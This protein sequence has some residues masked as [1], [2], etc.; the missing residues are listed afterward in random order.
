MVYICHFRVV[1]FLGRQNISAYSQESNG[2]TVE[3]TEIYRHEM[4]NPLH[5]DYALIK[6]SE[7]VKETNFI[8]PLCLP[9]PDMCNTMINNDSSVI[10]RCHHV[11]SAGWGNDGL[12]M[13]YYVKL[14][15]SF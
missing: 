6:L 2:K 9:S 12:S 1:V 13:N 15:F 14:T 3:S 4:Y 7:R 11:T 10:D 5:F 8:R